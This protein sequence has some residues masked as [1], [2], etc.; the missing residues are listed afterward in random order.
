[1]QLL[2]GT[3]AVCE[4]TA[5]AATAI[6]RSRPGLRQGSK[7]EGPRRAFALCGAARSRSDEIS[8]PGD[9]VCVAHGTGRAPA[10]DALHTEKSLAN[11]LCPTKA[12]RRTQYRPLAPA[13]FHSRFAQEIAN[14]PPAYAAD[15]DHT[16]V[17]HDT[18]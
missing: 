8:L 7:P 6:A 14:A 17:A 18:A 5:I 15:G 3:S 11:A 13:L 10:R 9:T 4:K 12:R 1:M 2:S 16:V